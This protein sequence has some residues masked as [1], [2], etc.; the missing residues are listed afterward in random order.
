M[1][2]YFN[3]SSF[4]VIIFFILITIII[5]TNS[6]F[7]PFIW[8]DLDLVYKNLLIRSFSNFR[9]IFVVDLF[10]K[11]GEI[12]SSNFYRPIQNF[13]YMLDYHFFGL[14]PFGYHLSNIIL[15]ILNVIL[16]YFLILFITRKRSAAFI[17]GLLFAVHPVHTEAVTYISGRAD[18]LVCLFML[19][20]ITFFIS[21]SRYRKSRKNIFYLLSLFCFVL[22]LLSK[23]LAI[24]F[25]LVLLLYDFTFRKD[26]FSDL[27]VFIK[28][29]VVFILIDLIYIILRL[30]KLQFNLGEGIYLTGHYSLYS[31]L[32][33]FFH[34]F[35][36][37]FRILFLPLDLHMC[38]IFT[39]SLRILNPI[40]FLCILS[41]LLSIVLLIY[42]YRKS[43]NIIFFSG[44]WYL[45]M[46]VPQSGLFYPINAFMADH[47]LYLPSI[48][49]FLI[50]GFLL[51]RYCSRKILIIIVILIIGFYAPIT[52]I[53]NYEWRNEEFFYKQIIERSPY[54]V[55]SYLNLGVY[56]RD[57]GLYKDAEKNFRKALSL[58]YNAHL[59]HY[60]LADVFVRMQRYDEAIEELNT[61]LEI[62][63]GFKRAEIYN[64]LGYIYQMK[65][66]YNKAINN[67]R[68]S[69][70]I[71]PEFDV[72]RFNL[73]SI[74]LKQDQKEKTLSEFEKILGLKEGIFSLVKKPGP[75][76]KEILQ[77]INKNKD[78]IGIFN[79]IAILFKKYNKNDIA[80]KI[81]K[82]IIELVPNRADAYFNLGVF[83]YQIGLQDK[84][85]QQWRE[86]L[87]L[88]PKHLPSKEWIIKLRTK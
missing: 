11:S 69:L 2:K 78:Y 55:D 74:Y 64:N 17:T 13:S 56:Y 53:R 61:I 34:V 14:N 40:T 23:E 19:L 75:T 18:L 48:G 84:A 15:H 80:E 45:I 7:N 3:K 8:D 32:I 6:L 20:S 88:N 25:P 43:K 42:S 83:Y 54:C 29:Y 73:V 57:R 28:R 5:Y 68:Y 1:S 36:I 38:R 51:S 82:K 71:K 63:P 4:S 9:K 67:Y 33:I 85:E 21:Y 49:F 12:A 65:K 10:Y 62:L 70:E 24:I 26:I 46:L 66:D 37:Y 22:A 31:R 52:V 30:T 76:K 27:G 50:I 60:Y 41:F 86:A 16:V 87:R 39:L 79:D 59:A 47:F 81:F 58:K 72:A 35:N 77:A 44:V